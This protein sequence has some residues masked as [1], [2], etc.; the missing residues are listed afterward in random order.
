MT[1]YIVTLLLIALLGTLEYNQRLSESYYEDELGYQ[2]KYNLFFFLIAAVF[3][4]VGGFRYQVGTDFSSYYS[5]WTASWP[6][7]LL[8]FQT[9]DEPLIYLLT[10]VCRTIW[11]EGI[12]VIFM[13][14]AIT[15]SLVLKGIRDW[16]YESWTMPLIMY[17]LY[18]G[19]TGSFNGVRQ[20]MAGAIIF[21]F[22]RKTDGNWILK[23][24]IVCFVAFLMHK[25]ALF[26]LPILILA[27]RKIDFRQILL[28]LG[29]GMAMPYMGQYALN[30]I[31]DTLDSNYA[32]HSVNIIRVFVAVVPLVLLVHSGDE[33][34]EKNHFLTNMALIN[35][36]IAI[37]TRNSALMYRFSDYTDM[38]LMLFIP[39][40]SDLFSENSKRMFRAVVVALYFAYF[41]I[42]IRSGNGHLNEFQW[43]FGYFGEW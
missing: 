33:F 16:E 25:T 30:F 27:N 4:F 8:K 10:N 3:F 14:N 42:E 34:R 40:L 43:A 24:A 13:E 20:A 29:A 22:S 18:C 26:M 38:Y 37:S 28:I 11:D 35:A 9:L 17:I 1:V 32:S 12:F 15:V 23:Y 21:A 6:D 19:W 31:G 7:L 36:L 39:R 5:G 2:K 41:A